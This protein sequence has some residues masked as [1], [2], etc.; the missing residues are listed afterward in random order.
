MVTKIHP[1][2]ATCGRQ[3]TCQCCEQNGQGVTTSEIRDS[4]ENNHPIFV[5][6]ASAPESTTLKPN[7]AYRK[8]NAL[9]SSWI[10]GSSPTMT[11]KLSY[12]HLS[13]CAVGAWAIA[14]SLRSS[15]RQSGVLVVQASAPVPSRRIAYFHARWRQ[16]QIEMTNYYLSNQYYP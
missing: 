3:T 7:S 11:I 8:K 16:L 9:T 15:Q 14:S 1:V 12:F 4:Y 10:V 2:A 13:W 5:I 6:P